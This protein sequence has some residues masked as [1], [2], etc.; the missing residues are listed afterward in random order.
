MKIRSGFVSNSSSS[1]FLMIVLKKDHEEVMAQLTQFERKVVEYLSKEFKA[2][3]L[4]LVKFSKMN[5]EDDNSLSYFPI[6]EFEDLMTEEEK[7]NDESKYEA[8]DK[9]E[10][11]LMKKETIK[12]REDW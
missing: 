1:S 12:H 2:F 4:N 8:V 5:S 7:K 10:Y 3:G 11:L 6:S 9:Y